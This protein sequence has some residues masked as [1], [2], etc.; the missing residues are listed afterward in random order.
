[1]EKNRPENK[2]TRMGEVTSRCS[3]SKITHWFGLCLWYFCVSVRC[4]RIFIVGLI[5]CWTFLA[6]DLCCVHSL[7]IGILLLLLLSLITHKI[8]RY[9][10][11]H[12]NLLKSYIYYFH[13]FFVSLC[14]I[15]TCALAWV[16]HFALD[17]RNIKWN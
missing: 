2:T 14:F 13:I 4:F 9:I 7:C 3:K 5:G 8:L 15:L 11:H 6:M 16:S 12:F 10:S 17:A 1:M